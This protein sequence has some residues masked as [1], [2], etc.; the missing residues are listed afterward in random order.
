MVRWSGGQVVRW[1]GA[2]GCLT[3]VVPNMEEA[4]AGGG[5]GGAER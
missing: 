5:G 3:C 2:E 1:L 4:V